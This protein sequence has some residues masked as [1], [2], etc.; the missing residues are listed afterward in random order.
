[1]NVLETLHHGLNGLLSELQQSFTDSV[2]NTDR[3][4]ASI[5]FKFL[6]AQSVLDL[7]RPQELKDYL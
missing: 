7:L 6:E 2:V 4:L 3:G 1:M 5:L